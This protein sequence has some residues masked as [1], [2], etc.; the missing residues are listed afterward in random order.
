[1]MTAAQNIE[2]LFSVLEPWAIDDLVGGF[3]RRGL[4]IQQTAERLNIPL[5]N[6]NFFALGHE[7]P[8]VK[9]RAKL[10]AGAF[11]NL[12]GVFV[13]P[14]E[15]VGDQLRF[16]CT[17]CKEWH[18]HGAGEGMRVA[19]CRK[20][21]SPLLVRDIYLTVSH[22]S[23][24]RCGARTRS[25]AP[26]KRPPVHGKKRC[27]NHGGKSTGPVTAEG[28]ARALANLKQFSGK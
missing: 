12:D 17:H 26:C 25:G 5:G 8:P 24:A 13:I 20:P 7:A 4:T 1:M 19:H 22:E 2:H 10:P 14:C 23:P 21:D 9:R 6:A 27:P 18:F 15:A 28:R 3:I 11:L 16:Y